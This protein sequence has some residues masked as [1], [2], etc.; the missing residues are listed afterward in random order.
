MRILKR[1]R[2][3]NHI[4]SIISILYHILNAASL[5]TLIRGAFCN[6]LRILVTVRHLPACR[7]T[8]HTSVPVDDHFNIYRIMFQTRSQLE[9]V[10]NHFY[11]KINNCALLMMNLF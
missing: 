10:Y 2:E 7:A 11:Q 8:R 3:F 6:L 5:K 4:K 1:A 9:T